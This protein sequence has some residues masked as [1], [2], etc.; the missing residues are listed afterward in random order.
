[1]GKDDLQFTYFKKNKRGLGSS[2]LL[3]LRVPII[4]SYRTNGSFWYI[5]DSENHSSIRL[6]RRQVFSFGPLV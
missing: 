2:G 5:P 3:M 1:M 4:E 6:Y